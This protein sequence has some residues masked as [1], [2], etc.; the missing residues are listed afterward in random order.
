MSLQR[1]LRKDEHPE[2]PVPAG[3]ISPLSWLS[4]GKETKGAFSFDKNIPQSL[5]EGKLAEETNLGR[6][7]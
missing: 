7:L 6:K 4:N 3:A 1:V 2:V 5:G